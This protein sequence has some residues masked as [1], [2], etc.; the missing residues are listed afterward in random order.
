MNLIKSSLVCILGLSGPALGECA[1]ACYSTVQC[2]TVQCSTIHHRKC[3][4]IG[5]DSRING[6]GCLDG[7][8]I[9]GEERQNC[10]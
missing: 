9:E 4:G 3:E 1:C 5:L 6:P 2:C 8:K 7:S 10:Y